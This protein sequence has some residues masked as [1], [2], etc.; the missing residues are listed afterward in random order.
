MKKIESE[1]R[2]RATPAYRWTSEG[3]IVRV[4]ERGTP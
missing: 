3:R 2:G 1:S 4:L